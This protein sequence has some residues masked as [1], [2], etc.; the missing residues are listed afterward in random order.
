MATKRATK[1]TTGSRKTAPTTST[2]K[3]SA[4]PSR[5]R[6]AK[7]STKTGSRGTAKTATPPAASVAAAQKVLRTVERREAALRKSL[8][9]QTKT[10]KKV[11]KSLTEHRDAV[12]DLETDLKKVKKTRKSVTSA[13]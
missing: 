1:K 2:T 7:A 12:K 10:I 9:Q 6:T 11:K 5:S 3:R 4:S 8:D 13:L